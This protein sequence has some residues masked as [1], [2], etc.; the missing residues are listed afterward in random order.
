MIFSTTEINLLRPPS[1]FVVE[2]L[3]VVR[4]VLSTAASLVAASV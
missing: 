3:L 2:T 4:T 1:S